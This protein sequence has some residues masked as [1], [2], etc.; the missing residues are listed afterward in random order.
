MAY[1]LSSSVRCRNSTHQGKLDTESRSNKQKTKAP[2]KIS[3]TSEVFE[4]TMLN[5]KKGGSGI[6]HRI[7]SE[8][9]VSKCQQSFTNCCKLQLQVSG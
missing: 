1:E 5:V 8:R 2:E 3:D 7:R 4:E 9:A 6:D